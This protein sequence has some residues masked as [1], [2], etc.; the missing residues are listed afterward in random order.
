MRNLLFTGNPATGK[1]FLA[2]AAAYYLCHEKLN[3][4]SLQSRDIYE[5]LDKI[6]AFISSDKCEFI[7]V[8]PSMTYE[9]IVYGIDIKATGSMT[10][11]YVEKRIKKLCDRAKLS[12]ELFA[13]V[14]DDISRIDASA[15]LGNLIYAMEFRN[16]S[17]V[18]AD[19]SELCIPDNVVLIFTECGDFHSGHLDYALH[20]RM[21]YVADLKSDKEIIEKY[22]E[23][24]NAN[25]GRIIT[26]IFES[27]KEF[28]SSNAVSGV[29]DVAEK[30]M[31]GHG[32]FIVDRIGTSYFVLDKFKQKMVYQIFPFL[33]NLSSMGIIQG[34]VDSFEQALSS[35]LNTGVSGL[36]R[37]SDIRK[38]M[39]NSGDRV[40]PYSLE[41][42]I[43]YYEREIIP[44]HCS[45]YKGLLESVIDAIVL[46]GVFPSDIATD[47]LLF[48]IEVASVPSKSVPVA[49]ASYLVKVQDA[50]SYYYETAVKGRVRRNPHAYYSTRPGNVGRWATRSDVAAYEIS[51][52]DGSP[53]D[54]YL[55]LNGLRLHTFTTNNVCKDNNPAEI[56]GSLYRLLLHYLKVYEM[57]ISLI[58]GHDESYADLDKLILLE[59][60]YLFSLHDELRNVNAASQ[61]ER[62][63]ARIDYFGTRIRRLRALWTRQGQTIKVDKQKFENLISGIISFSVGTY[64]D[65]Y[66]I[67]SG[68]EKIIEIKGVVKMTD[69]KDYQQVMENIGVRQMVFQ[70]PPGTSKTFESKKFVLKQLEPDSEVLTKRFVSQEDIS[71]ALDAYKLTEEDYTNPSVSAKLTTGGWDLVQFH[72]SYGY[73][74]FIRGIEVKAD[75]GLP[76]YN[77]VNRILGKIA[78]FAKIAEKTN[79]TVPPKFYLVIDEINRANIATV[80]GELIYGLEYRDSKVSTPYEVE[81]KVTDPVSRTKDIVLGKNLFIIGTMNTADK[82]ID[83][84]DYA[85]RR[86]FLFI[87]SPADRNVVISCY[88]N[89]SENDDENSIEL[90]V[91]DAVQAV[92]DNESYFNDEYQKNDVRLGHT[93]F[94]RKRKEGYEEDFV[95]HFVFQIIP[96]L[97][98]YVKDG[99]LDTIEDLKAIEHTP[100]EIRDAADRGEQVR[101]ISDNIMLYA[102]EFGN[103]T[104]SGKRID[105]EYVG[106]FIEEVRTKIGY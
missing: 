82:S 15:L 64:E 54:T 21:D 99:I 22:Y 79:P 88:Q 19:G 20:R 61:T 105:N 96:I 8:H 65:I 51:Y 13:V 70:G 31:P 33:N 14:F 4:D 37:I 81:D 74:D 91:F 98:E 40:D 44:N 94:L 35:K 92:F 9:D 45:D 30:Y 53:S 6:E 77:S 42:T 26:D 95:E 72:P 101:F 43:E 17:V 83:S 24:V 1:T 50:P 59:I 34:N 67:T 38:V 57:N 32:M 46:N 55:P 27:I 86:R 78:E 28:L 7:Q 29:P 2:R 49:Y 47:S 69:L 90:L 36:N 104:R 89:A 18:L 93:Y 80:F 75:G 58:K 25:A 62:E 103:M 100:S 56:Y 60:K 102:K 5:D 76:S 11:D 16:E 48:N 12:E 66:N 63:K 87:D 10:V 85:I 73:E 71:S 68:A 3:I 106:T 97:R 39:V 52:T 41:D 84:I 23:A